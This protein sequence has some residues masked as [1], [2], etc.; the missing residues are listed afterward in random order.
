MKESTEVELGVMKR[1]IAR[2][3]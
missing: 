1:F 2:V 3:W